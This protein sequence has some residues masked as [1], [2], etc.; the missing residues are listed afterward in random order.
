MRSSGGDRSDSDPPLLEEVSDDLVPLRGVD[1]DAISLEGNIVLLI[2]K[3]WKFLTAVTTVT[4]AQRTLGLV[5]GSLIP[6]STQFCSHTLIGSGIPLESPF[7]PSF[8]VKAHSATC[9]FTL[10]NSKPII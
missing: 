2:D 10:V 4:G 3:S 8:D 7:E 1:P 9:S 5:V 6:L